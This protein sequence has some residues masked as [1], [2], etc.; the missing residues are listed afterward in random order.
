MELKLAHK[1]TEVGVFPKDWI[2][3]P[4]LELGTWKGG[5][6]P[7][8]Q[9][10]AY[11]LNGT[12]PW[13]SSGDVKSTLISD[14][15][16][17]ITQLAV[18]E[19]SSTLLPNKSIIIVTRSGILRKYLPVAMNVK[20]V[21]INQDIK[22]IIARDD[23]FPDYLLHLLIGNGYKILASCMKSG[24][25]V[26][27]IEYSW[28]KAFPVSIPPTK[29]EQQAIAEVLND[30][31]ALIESLER[32]ITKKHGIKQATMQGLLSGEKRLLNFNEDWVLKRLDAVADIRSG[33][34]PSTNQPEFWN[35]EI[36]WCTPTDITGLNGYKY[37]TQ[38]SRTITSQ[39]LTNCS[40]ELL[41]AQ[42]VIMTSRATIGECAINAMPL[43]TNQGFKNFIPSQGIDS[44]FLY[45]LLQTKKQEF[46]G[47]CGG[48]TFL[49]INKTELSAF[50]INLPKDKA[51]QTAI[52]AILSDMDSEIATLEYRF[53]KTMMLKQGVMQGLLA[54][55]I[56][57]V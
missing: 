51:E 35:G 34:T 56:R 12:I 11:W 19:S 39:G 53:H 23:I 37:L 40:A 27:S 31:D 48:S 49:E 52:A 47:L 5:A 43:A 17:K 13:V 55:R 3:R 42:S 50:E 21:A 30:L 22:A 24:T 15:P 14:T 44:E 18:K 54:G 38:T 57:L 1:Q 28:L 20:P 8:M 45:Y 32:L 6:T 2:T 16:M 10:K 36:P 46:I 33:G 9:K 26:E 25:T 41:P 4:L 7:S 29:D